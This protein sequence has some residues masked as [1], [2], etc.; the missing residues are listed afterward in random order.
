MTTT[1]RSSGHGFGTVEPVDL[2]GDPAIAP[3]TRRQRIEMVLAMT[4]SGAFWGWIA[5][6]PWLFVTM[7]IGALCGAVFSKRSP[8]I[9]DRFVMWALAFGGGG[10]LA[11][12]RLWARM[13]GY[14]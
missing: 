2:A 10:T 13:R 5:S 11:A 9:R 8:R 6:S 3:W 12:G 1:S 14:Y 4:I 7:A